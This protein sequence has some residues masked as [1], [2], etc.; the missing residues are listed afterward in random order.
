MK[1]E[2]LSNSNAQNEV[3]KKISPIFGR[4][5]YTFY[6]KKE[7]EDLGLGITN[8]VDFKKNVDIPINFKLVNKGKN[9]NS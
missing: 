7:L 4:T 6:N 3:P 2:N 8:S 5:A 1:L 9:N